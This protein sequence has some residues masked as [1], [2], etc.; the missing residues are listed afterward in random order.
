M[1]SH[2]LT[3]VGGASGRAEIQRLP[4]H[5]ISNAYKHRRV[6]HCAEAGRKENDIEM[7]LKTVP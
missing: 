4:L 7:F 6:R 2:S 1:L 5:T 3:V